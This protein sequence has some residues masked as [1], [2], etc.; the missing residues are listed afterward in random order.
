MTHV[1][2]RTMLMGVLMFVNCACFAAP[3]PAIVPAYGQWTL[4]VE[5]TNLQ[6]IVLPTRGAE[7]Q[8]KYW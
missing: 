3:E 2:Y 5:F 4:D 8:E 7:R 6:Q 1:V